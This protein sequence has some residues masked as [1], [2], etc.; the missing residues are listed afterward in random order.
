M[1]LSLGYSVLGDICRYWIVLLLEVIFVVV[2]PNTI[3]IRQQ[4]ALFMCQWTIVWFRLWLTCTLTAAIV[5]LDTILICCCSLN[6]I[7]IIIIEFWGFTWYSGVYIS[8]QINI[9][10]CFTLVL[11]L[12]LGI[13]IARGQYYWI[14]DIGCLAWYVLTLHLII[15]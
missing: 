3:P 6:T 15:W 1:I 11:V 12:V 9:L 2:T 14:L 4:S 7:V 5:C 10:L 8:L 13:G